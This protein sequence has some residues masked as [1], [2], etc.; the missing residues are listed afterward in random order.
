M[1]VSCSAAGLIVTGGRVLL[2]KV[3]YG[4]N[5]G[6][7]MLPGGLVDEG[8]TF[9][10]AAVREVKEETGFITKVIRLIGIRDGVRTLPNGV[11]HG[12]YLVFEMEVAS[13]ALCLAE[14]EIATAQFMLI[15][16]ALHDP[17]VIDITK[18][19]IRTLINN[20]NG[21]YQLQKSIQTNNRW[22]K[23]EVLV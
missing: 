13:G 2:V 21:L 1:N 3:T 12:I 17:S 7:W 22:A 14:E 18:E 4:A 23:Y 15:E 11:E 5:K 19:M 16:E 10:E 6:N 20:N 8:E 9:Q